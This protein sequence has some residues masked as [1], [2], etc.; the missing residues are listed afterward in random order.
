TR[1]AQLPNLSVDMDKR[2]VQ[3]KHETKGEFEELL[4]K[5]IS[6]QMPAAY[7]ENYTEIKTLA[8]NVYPQQPNLIL[9]STGWYGDDIFKIWA[10]ENAERG[11]KLCGFQHGGHYG[12]ALYNSDESHELKIYDRYYTWGWKTEGNGETKILPAPKF[13][14]SKKGLSANPEGKLLLVL[15]VMPRYFYLLYSVPISASDVLEY[16]NDQYR[17]VRFLNEKCKESLLVRTYTHDY[18]W[19]Q[20]ERCKDEMPGIN[21]YNGNISLSEQLREARL[22][23]GTYEATTYLETFS[24][25]FPTILYWNPKHWELRE[26]AKPYFDKLKRAG[27]LHDS[28]DSAAEKVNE[29]FPDVKGWWNSDEV[30][31]AKDEFCIRFV[32]TSDKWIEEWKSEIITFANKN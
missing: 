22:F 6:E 29:I 28:P 11:V 20:K 14:K 16:W 21:V 25:N 24:S 12:T 23:I 30:Q 1:E 15:G 3:L 17:F 18:G 27:I 2:E 26:S 19:S 13:E 7:L 8:H 5:I 10:A 4:W 31:K 32:N 9:T